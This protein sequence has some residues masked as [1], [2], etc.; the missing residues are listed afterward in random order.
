MHYKT[1]VVRMELAPL[2]PFLKEM[3]LKEVTPQPKLSVSKS[4]LP[5]E[6]TV[7]VLDYQ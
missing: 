6:T 3:G 2:E 5:A 1:D 7:I 4:S